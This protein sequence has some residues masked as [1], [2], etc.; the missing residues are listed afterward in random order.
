MIY[1]TKNE[2]ENEYVQKHKGLL[3]IKSISTPASINSLVSLAV[4]IK[5]TLSIKIIQNSEENTYIYIY[6]YL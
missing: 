6:I 2:S 1:Y 3:T 5:W 4:L